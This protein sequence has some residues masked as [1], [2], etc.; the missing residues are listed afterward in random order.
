M[1]LSRLEKY[2]P[3]AHLADLGIAQIGETYGRERRYKYFT[4]ANYQKVALQ[5]GFEDPH[6]RYNGLDLSVAGEFMPIEERLFY[7]S[8]KDLQDYIN[9]SHKG[10]QAVGSKP[11][12]AKVYKN[13]LLPDGTVKKGRPRKTVLAGDAGEQK[14]AK[15]SGGKKRK[16]EEAS[17]EGVPGEGPTGKKK[18]VSSPAVET[19]AVEDVQADEHRV[20]Q[21]D[22]SISSAPSTRKPGRP[23]KH[24]LPDQPEAEASTSQSPVVS[25]EILVTA[26]ES[27]PKKRGRGSKTVDK[28]KRRQEQV[29][30]PFEDPDQGAASTSAAVAQSSPVTQTP[31]SDVSGSQT[32]RETDRGEDSVRLQV[33]SEVSAGFTSAGVEG[34]VDSQAPMDMSGTPH[35]HTQVPISE[36]MSLE[37]SLGK[38][39]VTTD[40]D[41][42]ITSGGAY[43]VLNS[44]QTI[45]NSLVGVSISW[46]LYVPTANLINQSSLTGA[47]VSEPSGHTLKRAGSSLPEPPAKKMKHAKSNISQA[48]RE[49]E[50]LRLITESGGI[51]NISSKEFYMAHAALIEKMS[52]EGEPTSTPVGARIDKRTVRIVLDTLESR[53]K[54]KVVTTA[55]PTPT[56][57]SRLV[58]IVCL[59]TVS[60]DEFNAF[61]TKVGSTSLHGLPQEI[62]T[63]QQ[64]VDFG[65]RSN[66]I[67]RSSNIISADVVRPSV[68]AG[69][70]FDSKDD[71]IRETIL[72]DK[73]TL[74]QL[75]GFKMGKCARA[76]ELHLSTIASIQAAHS[77]NNV[78]STT[79][80]IVHIAFWTED[81]DAATFCALVACLT[82]SED[83]LQLLQS[84]DGRRTPLSQVLPEIRKVLQLSRPR[85]RD[86]LMELLDILRFLGLVVPLKPSDAV[87]P[88]FTCEVHGI[89]PTAYDVASNDPEHRAEA[90]VPLY[91]RFND[92]ALL[93]LWALQDH[94]IPLWTSLPVSTIE[95]STHYW[96]QLQAVC[97]DAT[98]AEKLEL[99]P[100]VVSTMLVSPASSTP[101]TLR[102][103]SAWDQSYHMSWIQV[104]YL[105]RFVDVKE[106][107]TPL[108]DDDGGYRRLQDISRLSGMPLQVVRDFFE[109]S[110]HKQ[111]RELEKMR[112][113]EDKKARKARGA[114]AGAGLAH[115]AAEAKRQREH[116]WDEMIKRIHPGPL[117]GSAVIRL[118]HIRSTFL[119]GSGKASKKWETQVL[120]AVEEAR[121]ASETLLPVRRPTLS[122]PLLVAGRAPPPPTAANAPEKPIEDLIAQQGPRTARQ[123]VT[124]SRKK[125]SNAG[126]RDTPVT[127]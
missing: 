125:K 118:Q 44:E 48:R 76:R 77:S 73:T 101:K 79:Q 113:R 3:P 47:T 88:G 49:S 11:K 99:N 91:W 93:Y 97:T 115:R 50:L 21:L 31:R 43:T 62:K 29:D 116:V 5:E 26:E 1:I 14:K 71:V 111:L 72:N 106:A 46:S 64:P 96:Q 81:L 13:P 30:K 58:R 114:D 60:E 10:V 94:N 4:I 119:E 120:K 123:Q 124:K 89:H 35:R 8:E 20:D 45:D 27:R 15:S 36:G 85:T 9:S 37:E 34:S 57:S 74:A 25:H 87:Q 100:P 78:V 66:S 75:Y 53:Q 23:Q 110:Y 2:S 54:I 112:E 39:D 83:L 59:P 84:E 122:T 67:T 92:H 7:T 38:R 65:N 41:S 17:E 117:Q 95:E 12:K 69:S 40:F 52:K 102:R 90:I 121:I 56:G 109:S 55:V 51:I 16:H 24:P 6:S 32:I 105:K 22:N 98:H 126:K 103:S 104:E 108:Q 70:L 28:G 63:I 19:N 42:T 80:R 18:R 68:D 61:L 127:D 82:Y 33:L 107:R 86:R